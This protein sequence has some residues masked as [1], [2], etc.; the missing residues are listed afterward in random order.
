M[1]LKGTNAV[2]ADTDRVAWSEYNAH[3]WGGTNL[4]SRTSAHPEQGG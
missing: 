4:T 1:R 3:F 2:G